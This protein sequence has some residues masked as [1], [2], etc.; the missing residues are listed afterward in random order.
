MSNHRWLGQSIFT[1]YQSIITSVQSRSSGYDMVENA[2]S[3]TETVAD[4]T[5]I[6]D[7]YLV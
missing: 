5:S 7:K 3:P 4:S 6:L 2:V 1:G